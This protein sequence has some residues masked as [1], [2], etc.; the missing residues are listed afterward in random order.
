MSSQV[1]RTRQAYVEE[2]EKTGVFGGKRAWADVEADECTF[3][4]ADVSKDVSRLN[5]ALTVKRAPGAGVY[6]DVV[7]HHKKLVTKKTGK[8]VGRRP[9]TCKVVNRTMRGGTKLKVKAP[10]SSVRRFVP[11]AGHGCFCAEVM[12]LQGQNGL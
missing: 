8:R 9:R 11:Q 6:Y 7:I 1:A 3:D 4:R 5:P 2:K 12:G 10:G